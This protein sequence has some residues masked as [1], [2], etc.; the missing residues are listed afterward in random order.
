MAVNLSPVGGVAAQFFDNSGNVLTGGLLYSYLAGTTTPAVTYTSSNGITAN[1]NPVVLDAAGRVPSSGEIWLT[2]G[3]TYKFILQDQNAVQIATWDNIVGINSNFIAYTGQTETQTATQGQTI[4]TLTTIQYIPATNNLSVYINGSKQVAGTNFQETS[5][6]VVT[7]VD[8][9]NVGDIVEFSTAEAISTN[10]TIAANVAFTGFKGQTGN[11]QDLADDDGSDW[12]GFLQDGTGAVAISAQDK[13]R[14]TVSV[15]DFGAVGDGI[16]D[17]TAA[18]QNAL[19]VGG[20]IYIPQGYTFR[21]DSAPIVITGTRASLGIKS[22][23]TL[24]GGGTLYSTYI[25]SGDGANLIMANDSSGSISNVV[26]DGITLKTDLSSTLYN[27]HMINFIQ[28]CDN[29][30]V[31]NCILEDFTYWGITFT[32]KGIYNILVDNNRIY[33]SRATGIWVGYEAA[34]VIITNNIVDGTTAGTYG[35]VDDRIIVANHNIPSSSTTLTKNVVIANN[36]CIYTDAKGI[37]VGSIENCVI[38]G[39]VLER[40]RIP[41]MTIQDGSVIT[42]KNENVVISNNTIL[43]SLV[44]TAYLALDRF[45]FWLQGAYNTQVT[46]NVIKFNDVTA[47]MW[48]GIFEC[49]NTCNNVTINNNYCQIVYT[50]GAHPAVSRNAVYYAGA[51]GFYFNNNEIRAEQNGNLFTVGISTATQEIEIK[52]NILRNL[53]YENVG[54]YFSGLVRGNIENN[55]IIGGCIR[56]VQCTESFSNTVIRNNDFDNPGADAGSASYGIRCIELS[57]AANTYKGV[58]VEGNNEYD[59]RSPVPSFVFDAVFYVE[60]ST[61]F[62]DVANKNTAQNNTDRR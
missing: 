56:Y 32:D 17:D 8:G 23:T 62:N 29:I 4:F 43:N 45:A 10:A 20:N 21:L 27:Y 14:Q 15:K 40:C 54:I 5:T 48:R 38:D 22:N 55:R 44:N 36:I 61:N 26:I 60:N 53:A 46:G 25:N 41:I 33:G 1:S 2:D 31:K 39:N 57:G 49:D 28:P 19:N 58:V 42:L 24:Y 47:P 9:L 35:S 11:V 50:S 6:T 3:L 7:F 18:I 13:M 12:I 34:N 16:T 30:T 37:S 52:N 59:S 51:L